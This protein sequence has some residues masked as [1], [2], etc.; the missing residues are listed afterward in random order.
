VRVRV[1]VRVRVGVGVVVVVGV[2]VSLLM[3]QRVC[4]SNICVWLVSMIMFDLILIIVKSI[5]CRADVLFSSFSAEFVE[6]ELRKWM[7]LILLI[8]D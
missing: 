4:L 1:R 2:Q 7:L 3:S 8:K 5:V 6:V